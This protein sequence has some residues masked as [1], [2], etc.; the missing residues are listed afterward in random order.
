ME[1]EISLAT[2]QELAPDQASLNAAKKLLKPTQWPMREKAASV[3]SIWGQCQGSGANPYYTMADVVDHG[4]K[5][6]CP[7]RKFP[8]KHVLALMWQFAE[9]STDFVENKPPEWVNDWLRRRRKPGTSSPAEDKPAVKKS[10]NDIQEAEVNSLSPEE[11][12]KKEAAR[13]K[14]AVQS[15][16]NT[17]ASISAGLTE[18]QQWVDDQLRT[19]IGSFI[20]EIKERS[21]RMAA[22]LVDAK[23]A[24][25]ASRLD[26]FPAKVMAVEAEQ[27][28]SVAFKE[29]GQLLLLSEAW[30]SDSDDPDVRSA[31]LTAENREQVLANS[32][33]IRVSGIWENVGEK[34]VTRRDG[35]V[36]HS[37]WLLNT[38]NKTASF[39]LLLDY[40]PASAGRREVGLSIGARLEG[41]LAFYPSRCPT[42]AILVEHKVLSCDR[43]GPWPA[44]ST[45]L[46]PGYQ[47]QLFQ[48]PW[49]EQ[50]PHLLNAGRI[51]R[52]TTG[53]YWWQDSQVQQSLP[54]SNTTL[55]PLLL[56]CD[57]DAAF[58][59]WDG[60]RADVFS[61]YTAKWGTIAC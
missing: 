20:K 58:I 59:I 37:T 11:D 40:Y 31:I 19:G 17:D 47:Q 3:N 38:A 53:N 33:A 30:F 29:L 32:N 41:E 18:F 46:L 21:R 49:S 51:M 57:L 2:V 52:D 50:Y 13:Q 10:I 28:A 34:V 60:D 27:K 56:G 48:L 15:K 8:C 4:Y 35:L 7:S 42:R 54:L 55:P 45:D 25:L 44:S 6:T 43:E 39:A 16:L 1:M 14:R 36:S 12:A 23:A 26:E 9:G 24:S 61:V 5:C 22:R